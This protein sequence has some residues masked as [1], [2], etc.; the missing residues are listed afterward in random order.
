MALILGTVAAGFLGWFT[1]GNIVGEFLATRLNLK[2]IS[3]PAT[4]ALGT[5]AITFTLGFLGAVPFV[6]GE[7]LIW[8][9]IVALGLGATALTKFGTRAY[10]IVTGP[11]VNQ[12]KV[13]AVLN[14]LPDKAD[15]D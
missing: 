11:V 12:D 3:Q 9:T 6:I 14:T 8:M 4:T 1:V 2:T 7:S 15:I 5:M 13:T 10:P